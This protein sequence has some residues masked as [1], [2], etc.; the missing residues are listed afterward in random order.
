MKILPA[1]AEI[2]KFKDGQCFCPICDEELTI[3]IET[4]QIY[5]LKCSNSLYISSKKIDHNFTAN[6]IAFRI[7]EDTKLTRFSN[8]R[9]DQFNIVLYFEENKTYIEHTYG[10][11]KFN[12][13]EILNINWKDFSSLIE[14][15]DM[16]IFYQ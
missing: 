13:D 6:T 9:K 11:S 16:L 8:K 4:G 14:K 7:P 12:L 3:S 1:I 2:I 10:D 5:H 15:I